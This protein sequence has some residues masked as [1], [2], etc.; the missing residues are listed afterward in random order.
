MLG[1][2]GLSPLTGEYLSSS[3]PPEG[4]DADKLDIGAVRLSDD[5]ARTSRELPILQ[6]NDLGFDDRA[7][8]GSPPSK[9]YLV[10]GYPASKA[11]PRRQPR[12]VT[13]ETFVLT[14][15]ALPP[16]EYRRLD[17]DDFSHVALSFDQ[18]NVRNIDGQL[19]AP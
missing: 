14:A 19:T 5:L 17:V 4:R 1:P 15:V 8:V 7:F 16:D 2:N 3:I 11:K 13:A 10:V 6:A 12:G 9:Q 18:R